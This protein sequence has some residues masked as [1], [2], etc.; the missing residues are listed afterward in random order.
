MLRL[1]ALVK[2]TVRNI[3]RAR[4]INGIPKTGIMIRIGKRI[5]TTMKSNTPL[6]SNGA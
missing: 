1:V 2:Y 5:S 6:Q 4:K 3:K